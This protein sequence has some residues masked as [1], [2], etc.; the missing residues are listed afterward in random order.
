LKKSDS[1][2]FNLK[3]HHTMKRRTFLGA[4]GLAGAG[5][6]SGL[7]AIANG[8]SGWGSGDLTPLLVDGSGNPITTLPGWKEE[9]KQVEKRWRNYLGIIEF[10]P[11]PPVLKVLREDYPEGLVRQLVEYESEPGLFVQGYLIRP[12]IVSNPLPG[13]VV[14]HSTS[15]RLSFIAGLEENK[16]HAFG[17]KMAQQ[18]VV[19]FCPLCFLF[20]NNDDMKALELQVS[21]FKSRHPGSKGMAKMLFDAS[22]AVDILVSMKE[23]D[24]QRIGTMGHSLGAKEAL[25]LAAFD[26]RVKAAVF[27]EGGI[28]IDFSNWDATWYLDHDIHAFGHDHHELLALTA[29]KPFLLIGGESADGEKSR[30]YVDAALP[31]YSLYGKK[32]NLQFYNHGTGHDVTPDAENRTYAW[33]KDHL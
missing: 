4:T 20:V 32:E 18:G 22:R 29:P 28:G 26:N 25:Y 21:R 3:F 23:V 14:L 12:Q 15:Y 7:T 13:V 30:M 5:F 27:N 24:P 1:H 17:Y 10:N 19:V 6:I 33:M 11:S 31:V 9:R 2:G 16:P 8:R